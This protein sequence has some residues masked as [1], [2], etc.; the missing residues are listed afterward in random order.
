VFVSDGIKMGRV[1]QHYL[2]LAP[3]G[4]RTGISGFELG[5]ADDYCF[6]AKQFEAQN[7]A[8]G[9]LTNDALTRARLYLR[10][11]YWPASVINPELYS[12]N[13]NQFSH[14]PDT[15]QDR[16]NRNVVFFHQNGLNRFSTKPDGLSIPVRR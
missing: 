14:L 11:F 16:L 5:V 10:L 2:C 3:A 8:V 13:D 7:G 4:S 12:G 6:W 9:L 15:F 1:A